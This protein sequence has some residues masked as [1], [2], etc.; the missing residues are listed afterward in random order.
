MARLSVL[1]VE[2]APLVTIDADTL[3]IGDL[4][5]M[6]RDDLPAV[7]AP[8]EVAAL[9]ERSRRTFA[10]PPPTATSGRTGGGVRGVGWSSR[11]AF[12][13]LQ[14]PPLDREHRI[15]WSFGP[16]LSGGTG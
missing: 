9:R 15:Q 12:R 11:S 7:A 1:E 6:G 13:L 16:I 2:G 14:G 4:N 5:T 10:A 8:T 3:V